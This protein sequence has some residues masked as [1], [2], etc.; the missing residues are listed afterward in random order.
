[1]IVGETLHQLLFLLWCHVMFLWQVSTGPRSTQLHHAN[2][3][4]GVDRCLQDLDHAEAGVNHEGKAALHHWSRET[5]LCC[6]TG[7]C[8]HIP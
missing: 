8:L 4:P 6:L 3:L 1:L 5:R 2:V 7:N